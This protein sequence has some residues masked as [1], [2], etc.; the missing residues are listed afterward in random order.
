MKKSFIISFGV[1][2]SM[3]ALLSTGIFASASSIQVAQGT[4]KKAV[5]KATSKAKRVKILV[6]VKGTQGADLTEGVS[7]KTRASVNR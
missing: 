3:I 5:V 2:G 6:R 1:I 4:A 7:V